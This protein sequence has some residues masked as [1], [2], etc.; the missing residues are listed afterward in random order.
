MLIKYDTTFLLRK[1]DIYESNPFAF[2]QIPYTGRD[3]L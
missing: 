1:D 3:R 2:R